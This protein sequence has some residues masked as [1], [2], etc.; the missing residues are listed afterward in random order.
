[1]T[2]KRVLTMNI[3]VIMKDGKPAH[4]TT[5][6]RE[7]PEQYDQTVEH[8]VYIV[9]VTNGRSNQSQPLTSPDFI[10]AF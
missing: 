9:N 10:E 7:A 8:E 4:A 5:C 6:D 1:M 3:F 2:N